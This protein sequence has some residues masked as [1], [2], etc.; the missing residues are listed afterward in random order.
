MTRGV[1]TLGHTVKKETIHD[2][3]C[4]YFSHNTSKFSPESYCVF[5]PVQT[6]FLILPFLHFSKSP[7]LPHPRSKTVISLFFCRT[8]SINSPRKIKDRML[9]Q[10]SVT[11]V[12]QRSTEDQ[13]GLRI[14]NHLRTYFALKSS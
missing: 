10:V 5:L 12:V 9:I 13:R 1:C 4:A 2:W 7:P 6:S 11:S 3:R 14:L 8:R